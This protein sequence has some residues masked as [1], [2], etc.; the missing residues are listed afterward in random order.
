MRH[1]DPEGPSHVACGARA[2]HPFAGCGGT[3]AR[4]RKYQPWSGYT[5]PRIHERSTA[6]ISSDHLGDDIMI[7]SVVDDGELERGGARSAR[8]DE[9]HGWRVV[10]DAPLG[11]GH[12]IP[13]RLP[14]L[15]S[16]HL[17]RARVDRAVLHAGERGAPSRGHRVVRR[18]GARRAVLVRSALEHEPASAHLALRVQE[19]Q[20]LAGRGSGELETDDLRASGLLPLEPRR[21]EV[22][23]PEA[24]RRAPARVG[25][26]GSGRRAAQP[27]ERRRAQQL[28]DLPGRELGVRR[29]QRGHGAAHERR[30]HARA[31]QPPVLGAVGGLVA[32]GAEDR[33]SRG[34]QVGLLLVARVLISVAGPRAVIAEVGDP[35]VALPGR[36]L[37]VER[38]DREH[39]IGSRR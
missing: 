9:T 36:A 30:R 11:V 14:A 22:E 20:D 3:R 39:A 16:R 15:G 24:H 1:L 7:V 4:D 19:R 35:V 25:P 33:D 32:V 38:P 37:V 17:P 12:A 5:G 26:R 6:A 31:A 28:G 21:V 8:T 27:P 34:E 2:R 10:P 18:E 23:G 13:E 29:A